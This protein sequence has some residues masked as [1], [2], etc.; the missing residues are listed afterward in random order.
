MTTLS[1]LSTYAKQINPQFQLVFG[2]V[3]NQNMVG[4]PVFFYHLPR[5]GGT[6]FEL[7]MSSAII[8]MQICLTK[9]QGKKVTLPPVMRVRGIAQLES[10]N[11]TNAPSI[12]LSGKM[13]YGAH[14]LMNNKTVDLYTVMREPFAMLCSAYINECEEQQ[15]SPEIAGFLTF[16]A[17]P[18]HQNVC[19]KI[20]HPMAYKKPIYKGVEHCADEVIANLQ[21]NF[22]CYHTTEQINQVIEH[23]LSSYKLPNVMMPKFRATAYEQYQA[24]MNDVEQ[25]QDKVRELNH[26]DYRVYQFITEQPRVWQNLQVRE[27]NVSDISCLVWDVS[28]TKTPDIRV[29]PVYT[30]AM[31]GTLYDIA[32]NGIGMH[33]IVRLMGSENLIVPE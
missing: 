20:L 9:E 11:L 19:S 1:N 24:F 32:H 26:D 21:Q 27:G 22:T 16:I 14:K 31:A 7:A 8:A 13:Q 3:L 5:S 28:D 30:K 23:A 15:V 29:Q 25:Y 33:H 2:R 12:M 10:L 18:E 4:N 17:Q 6:S